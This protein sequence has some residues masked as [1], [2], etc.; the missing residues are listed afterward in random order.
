M[1]CRNERGLDNL[2]QASKLWEFKQYRYFENTQKRSFNCPGELIKALQRPVT[3]KLGIE[4]W[5]GRKGI[6][7][8]RGI[9]KCLGGLRV[10]WI[11]ALLHGLI[12]DH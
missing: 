3:F 4:K 8:K 12:G 9:W 2:S 5:R 11:W 10:T 7:A 6:Q 1:K